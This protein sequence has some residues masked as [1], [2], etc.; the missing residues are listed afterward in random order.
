[1]SKFLID[2]NLSP[3]VAFHLRKC[4]YRAFAVRDLGLK[5]KSDEVI[6]AFAIK[7]L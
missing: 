1:M 7:V 5:G 6:L 4:G 3:L 2:E